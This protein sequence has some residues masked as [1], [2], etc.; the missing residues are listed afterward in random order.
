M[1]TSGQETAMTEQEFLLQVSALREK[2]RGHVVMSY[3]GGWT[4]EAREPSRKQQLHHQLR[5]ARQLRA[6]LEAAA[7]KVEQ[8]KTREERLEILREQSVNVNTL[9]SLTEA[10]RGGYTL[11]DYNEYTH[12]YQKSDARGPD[13]AVRDTAKTASQPATAFEEVTSEPSLTSA[14]G[15]KLPVAARRKPSVTSKYPATYKDTSSSADEEPSP[16]RSAVR[17]NNPFLD[18]PYKGRGPASTK[19]KQTKSSQGRIQ[20]RNILNRRCHNCKSSSSY[21]RR[22]QYW[23]LTGSKC[24]KIYC[25]RCL[26]GKYGCTD[27]EGDDWKTNDP[28]WQ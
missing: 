10:V 9:V 23:H 27:A 19:S 26:I 6:L 16:K 25:S 11:K 24:N 21:F 12:F 13:G 8:A 1:S 20:R 2:M 22:C 7:E 5:L 14:E 3:G 15:Q 4:A 17:N 18:S 28:D